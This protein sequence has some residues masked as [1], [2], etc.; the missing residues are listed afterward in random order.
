MSELSDGLAEFAAVLDRLTRRQ[1]GQSEMAKDRDEVRS[2]RNHLLALLDYFP[3]GTGGHPP[4]TVRS[5]VTGAAEA[6]EG[7]L[8]A[9]RPGPT[10]QFNVEA[11]ARRLRD[12]QGT[13]GAALRGHRRVVG[14]EVLLC[15]IE[16]A[17]R[18]LTDRLDRNPPAGTAE[19]VAAAFRV[20]VDGIIAV[21]E[22]AG[23]LPHL[24]DDPAGYRAEAARVQAAAAR[25]AYRAV[26][27][28]LLRAAGGGRGAFLELVDSLVGFAER[29]P[30]REFTAA[31]LN[32]VLTHIHLQLKRMPGDGLIRR[33]RTEAAT[34]SSHLAAGAGGRTIAPSN[35]PKKPRLRPAETGLKGQVYSTIRS[36]RDRGLKEKGIL[37]HLKRPEE[38]E[39]AD[40]VDELLQKEPKKT[41]GKNVGK[42]RTRIDVIQAALRNTYSNKQRTSPWAGSGATS[43]TTSLL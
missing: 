24:W 34:A 1:R 12:F 29:C 37:E 18:Q 30:D 19:S 16:D 39:L 10:D 8:A 41:R 22:F 13:L 40:G 9:R 11:A 28:V 35:R 20:A 4:A 6:A 21:A 38:K 7:W 26:E 31:D 14:P 33:L 23:H 32:P 27:G 15:P 42:K 43:S 5:A 25:E 3:D 17:V 36:L 2:C